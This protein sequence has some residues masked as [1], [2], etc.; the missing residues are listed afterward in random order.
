M[1]IN[2]TAY[3]AS[4]EV[5]LLL[6]A[7]R[8]CPCPALPE[9]VLKRVGGRDGEVLVLAPALNSRLRHHMSDTDSTLRDARERMS[10]TIEA[11]RREGLTVRGEVGHADP[12]AAIADA[13]VQ[14]PAGEIMI[15]TWPRA[16]SNWLEK[17]LPRRAAERFGIPIDHVIS[18]YDAPIGS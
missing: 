14:F 5:R 13:L 6:V 11:L 7:N 18:A 1:S 16:T 17:D 8:T 9:H 12:L 3:P 2:A 15:S 4:E 10:S